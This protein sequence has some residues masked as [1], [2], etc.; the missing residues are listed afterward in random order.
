M[1]ARRTLIVAALVA[2]SWRAAPA[3]VRQASPLLELTEA[4]A[5]ARVSPDSLTVRR[6]A[7]QGLTAEFDLGT[8]RALPNPRVSIGYEPVLG[9][10]E[11]FAIV[12]QALPVT[13]RR[14][15]EVRAAELR[16]EAANLRA[17][18][19]R[20]RVDGEVRLA[21]ATLLAAQ[22]RGDAIEAA[23]VRLK[24][25]AAALAKREEA[26]DVA[27]FDRL[28]ADREAADIDAA[29]ADATEIRTRAQVQL[30]RFLGPDVDPRRLRAVA[31]AGSAAATPAQPAT[32]P[33]V[34]TL[35]ERAYAARRDLQALER[36]L[37]ASSHR[38]RAIE[39]G[40][41]PEPE[42]TAGVRWSDVTSGVDGV[43]A[44]GVT[45]PLFDRRAPERARADAQDRNV[46]A[47]LAA[48]KAEIRSD[49]LGLASIVSDRRAAVERFRT[50]A[51]VQAAEIEEVALVSY[52][53]GVRTVQDL[54]DAYRAG[55]AAR[56][57]LADLQLALRRAEVELETITGEALP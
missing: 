32:L 51:I 1:L 52:E 56:A 31:D 55:A 57:R 13:G 36:E 17:E 16:L 43:F 25:L 24:E 50:T 8:A 19:V 39:R 26:G 27:G 48:Q 41:V 37:E 7:A 30:A 20:R 3:Q 14:Q 53:N 40:R 47:T 4:A 34:D 15:H 23:A 46:G 42:L 10:G 28:R 38:R 29:L 54:L 6:L 11:R 2:V 21:F 5:L 12:S 44:V 45:I 22:R 49:V 18:D 9:V 33:P 35:V